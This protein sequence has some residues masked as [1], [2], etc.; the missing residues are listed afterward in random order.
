[1]NSNPTNVYKNIFRAKKKFYELMESNIIKRK[2]HQ[3]IFDSL[4]LKN[5]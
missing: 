1:M 2:I 4:F 3:D 5:R